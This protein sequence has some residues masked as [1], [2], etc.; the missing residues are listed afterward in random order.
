MCIAATVDVDEETWCLY[1]STLEAKTRYFDMCSCTLEIVSSS[2]SLRQ[3]FQLVIPSRSLFSA[4]GH[5]VPSE[6]ADLVHC[7]RHVTRMTLIQSNISTLG[8]TPR[9]SHPLMECP[10]ARIVWQRAW[11]DL[12]TS[13]CGT[14]MP[15][16]PKITKLLLVLSMQMT[17]LFN[18]SPC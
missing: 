1:M 11:P 2:Q 10:K 7:Q 14:Y 6:T 16:S 17:T 4:W 18:I 12:A 9:H 13:F 15:R 8:R 5:V 3:S